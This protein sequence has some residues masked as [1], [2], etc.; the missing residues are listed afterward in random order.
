MFETGLSDPIS[1]E[2]SG[3]G[4]ASDQVAVEQTK[5]IIASDGTK[6]SLVLL[7]GQEKITITSRQGEIFFEYFPETG[8]CSFHVSNGGLQVNVPHG[9]IAFS[10]GRNISLSCAGR[11]GLKGCNGIDISSGFNLGTRV[12]RISMNDQQIQFSADRVSSNCFK[13]DL[14]S[15]NTRFRGKRLSARVGSAKLHLGL[16][17]VLSD[18]I[19]HKSR[20]V[21]QYVEDIIQTRSGRMR[22]FV[23]GLLHLKGQ[24][25]YIKAEK[26]VKVKGD[27]IHL[28]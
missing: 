16:L 13:A 27:R 26:D 2:K 18:T 7:Q 19:R 10:S 22:T 21:Y 11:L 14:S 28:R 8:K 25:T 15:V 4:Y 24:R 5:T 17:E 23:S 1:A 12:P 20:K 9:D 6:A 3:V